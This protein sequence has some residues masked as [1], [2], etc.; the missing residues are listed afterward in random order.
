MKKLVLLIAVTILFSCQNSF[1]PDYYTTNVSGVV[2]NQEDGQTINNAEVY[3][4]RT[5]SYNNF[6]T[7]VTKTEI[8]KRTATDENGI[9]NL[10]VTLKE[11][12]TY[13]IAAKK[14]GYKDSRY[15]CAPSI[16]NLSSQ[17]IDI[18]LQK[19]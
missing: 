17:R 4:F 8:M 1:K 2:T 16:K 9:Y 14:P 10:Y 15:Y 6:K 12:H 11:A 5:Y 13:H 18:Q 7:I 3:V 19:Y